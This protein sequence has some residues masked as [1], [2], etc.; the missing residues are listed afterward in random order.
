MTRSI[1]EDIPGWGSLFGGRA[2]DGTVSVSIGD[3]CES[4]FNRIVY[5][6]MI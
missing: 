5:F 6:L 4:G 3:L 1:T 2:G